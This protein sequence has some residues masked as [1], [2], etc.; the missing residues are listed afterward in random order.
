MAQTLRLDD[1]DSQIDY[2]PRG[3][4][5]V[6]NNSGQPWNLDG[7]YH[8]ASTLVSSFFLAFR[9]EWFSWPF[10]HIVADIL[11]SGIGT[12]ISLYGVRLPAGGILDLLFDGENSSMILNSATN[13]D[14][15]LWSKEELVDGDHQVIG[16]VTAADGHSMPNFW[17]DYFE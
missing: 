14:I 6:V 16:T 1:A 17:L 2:G 13:N 9:G 5:Q 8:R 3:S 10:P 11:T 15:S 12:S 4:W 7:T